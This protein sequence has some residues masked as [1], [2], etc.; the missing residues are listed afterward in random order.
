[1]GGLFGHQL[2]IFLIFQE[3]NG[4]ADAGFAIHKAPGEEAHLDPPVE[5]QVDLAAKAFGVDDRYRGTSRCA[6]AGT[7]P[8]E[9][10][11]QRLAIFLLEHVF[12]F[13]GLAGHPGADDGVHGVVGG[14]AVDGDPAQFL[15]F[16]PFGKFAVG[17]RMLDHVAHFI[18][19][20][21][22]PAESGGSRCE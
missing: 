9:E 14:A 18:G 1:M 6:S 20:G 7:C 5:Q 13:L 2:I 11:L 16:G 8:R 12:G 4:P 19:G 17:T 10:F 3:G 22:V 15:G 21:L